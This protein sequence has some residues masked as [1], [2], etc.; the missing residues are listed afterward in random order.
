M[1]YDAHYRAMAREA[2]LVRADLEAARGAAEALARL[3]G[4]AALGPAVGASVL[5]AFAE[6]DAGIAALPKDP[7]AE[8]ARTAGV[9][10][11]ARPPQFYRAWET[12]EAVRATFEVQR[13]RLAASTVRLVLSRQQVPALDRLLQAIVASDLG[14]ID[15]VMDDKMAALITELLAGDRGGVI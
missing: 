4:I 2:A 13:K 8:H 12:I 11:G 7:G 6:A 15:R 3:D 10:L 9:T 5:R 14:G 1:A